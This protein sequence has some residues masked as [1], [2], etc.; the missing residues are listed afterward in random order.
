MQVDWNLVGFAVV[1]SGWVFSSG[2]LL[3]KQKE[4]DSTILRLE[5]E[6]EK[7]RVNTLSLKEKI[8]QI[9]DQCAGQFIV[10]QKEFL[11][12]DT[13]EGF[14]KQY[15]KD[16]NDIKDILR[17]M[18]SKRENVR[19]LMQKKWDDISQLLIRVEKSLPNP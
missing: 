6:L 12:L 10:C 13:F 3:Q 5:K 17:D 4:Q 16:I 1:V 18:D 2:K 14:K 15:D 7:E 19:G 9:K 11:R 8:E